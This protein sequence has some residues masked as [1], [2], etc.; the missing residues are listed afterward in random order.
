[1]D[2]FGINASEALVIL[3]VALAVLPPKQVLNLIRAIRS[4]MDRLR[5]FSANTRQKVQAEAEQARN[6]GSEVSAQLRADGQALAASGQTVLTSSQNG[7]DLAALGSL[8][9]SSRDLDPRNYIR[10]VVAEEMQA[11][12]EIAKTPSNVTP[13]TPA[14]T[15]Q[16][17][18]SR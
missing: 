9:Q 11:W 4:G 6:S 3:L 10:Q 5:E 7:F 15:D 8:A 1:M 13:A 17:I 16:N 12:A 2:F 14:P 18:E